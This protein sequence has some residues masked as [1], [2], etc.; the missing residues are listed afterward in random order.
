MTQFAAVKIDQSERFETL[1][2]APIVEAVIEVR[3]KPTVPWEANFVTSETKPELRDYPNVASQDEF[4]Q[5]VKFEPGKPPETSQ[6]AA[7]KGLRFQSE[8][9]KQIVQFNKDGFLFSRLKP[10]ENWEKF[11]NEAFRLMAIYQRIAKPK[12]LTRVGLRFINRFSLPPQEAEFE[13]YV[14]TPPLP[15]KGLNLPFFGF[16]HHETLAIPGHR[17]GINLIRTIQVPQDQLTQGLAIIL[18]IDVFTLDNTIT[19]LDGLQNRLGEMR[20]L[21]NKVF[22]GSVTPKAIKSFKQ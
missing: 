4:Q 21:K 5:G 6:S 18:D 19:E 13:Q 10:Y 7:W 20:W 1:S 16:L 22:F 2:K 14:E 3:C 9:Q 15:P 12:E 17:Y 8:D 11:S